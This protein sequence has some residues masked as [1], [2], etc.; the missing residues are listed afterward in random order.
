MSPSGGSQSGVSQTGRVHCRGE[1]SRAG[2]VGARWV[3]SIERPRPN[4]QR[5]CSLFGD[6]R[7]W[8]HHTVAL[9]ER[10]PSMRRV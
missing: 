3:V 2:F 4:G 7:S 9:A 1:S 5:I 10:P 6:G 8:T